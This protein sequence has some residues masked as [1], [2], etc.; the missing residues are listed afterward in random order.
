MKQQ[1]PKLISLLALSSGLLTLPGSAENSTD[2]FSSRE[3]QESKCAKTLLL[4]KMQEQFQ[5][6]QTLSKN[7]DGFDERVISIN[8]TL[9]QLELLNS[10]TIEQEYLVGRTLNRLANFYCPMPRQPP[11]RFDGAERKT[12]YFKQGCDDASF[13]KGLI[14]KKREFELHNRLHPEIGSQIR[15]RRALLNWYIDRGHGDGEGLEQIRILGELLNTSDPNLI[16]PPRPNACGRIIED[17]GDQDFKF[18]TG[19]ACGMG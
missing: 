18:T 2:P 5:A 15:N 6:L 9:A 8:N 14:F 12:Y 11:N 17:S 3:N 13:A 10:L 7:S 1:I 19:I 4:E 16:N